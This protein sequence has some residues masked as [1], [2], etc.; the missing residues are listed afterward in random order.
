MSINELQLELSNQSAILRMGMTSEYEDMRSFQNSELEYLIKQKDAKDP[1]FHE[2]VEEVKNRGL[3]PPTNRSFSSSS[4]V[5]RDSSSN[6]QAVRSPA[7][8]HTSTFPPS[9]IQSPVEAIDLGQL[10]NDASLSPFVKFFLDMKVVRQNWSAI[11]PNWPNYVTFLGRQ[12]LTEHAFAKAI[13]EDAVRTRNVDGL[14][15]DMEQVQKTREI[16]KTIPETMHMSRVITEVILK[17]AEEG[18]IEFTNDKEEEG[19]EEI[20]GTMI[21]R[22][23]MILETVSKNVSP[24][25]VNKAT[26]PRQ[27]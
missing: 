19:K 9:Q 10:K 22:D 2:I 17:M 11:S 18:V 1:N 20:S 5:P 12:L 23:V 4:K 21:L 27:R 14:P 7:S 25:N 3:R 16:A 26:D 24:T 6:T 13:L 8:L 15:V